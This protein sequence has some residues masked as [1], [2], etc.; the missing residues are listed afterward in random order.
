MIQPPRPPGA[1]HQPVPFPDGRHGA[2]PAGEQADGGTWADW[3][4]VPHQGLRL[5]L[6][7]LATADSLSRSADLDDGRR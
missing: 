4:D 2:R 7:P 1:P 5:Q 6:V 3:V